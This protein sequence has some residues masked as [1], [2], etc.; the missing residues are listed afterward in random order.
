MRPTGSPPAA[1]LTLRLSKEPSA[2]SEFTHSFLSSFVLETDCPIPIPFIVL[3]SLWLMVSTLRWV[4]GP[5]RVFGFVRNPGGAPAAG[6][7]AHHCFIHCHVFQPF[8]F[9]D[10]TCR[11]GRARGLPDSM[12]GWRWREPDPSLLAA[13]FVLKGST[14]TKKEKQLGASVAHF[15]NG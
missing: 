15:P 12:S 14:N 8:K 7:R 1:L 6:R 2:V 10:A 11:G 5:K 4:L 3:I 9:S 13:V